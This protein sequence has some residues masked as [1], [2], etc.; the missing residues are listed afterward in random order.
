MIMLDT[1]LEGKEAV[2]G[3]FSM[4]VHKHGLS[5]GGN[6]EYDFGSFDQIIWQEQ[7]ESIYLRLPFATIRGKLDHD[8][9]VIQFKTPYL[10]KHVLNIGLDY[11]SN[12]LLSAVGLNQFQAPL[13]TDGHIPHRDR[14]KQVGEHLIE[15]LTP[16]VY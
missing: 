4:D 7:G 14:W 13:D 16:Y 15:Q 11:D 5:L 1:A 12:S 10:I 9:T 3:R 8:E 2:F 6:W